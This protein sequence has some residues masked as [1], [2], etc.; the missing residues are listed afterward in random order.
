MP[1]RRRSDTAGGPIV[2]ERVWLFASGRHL[3]QT[4]PNLT[5]FDSAT[6]LTDTRED[7]GAAKVTVAL[8]S[9]Q[10]LEGQWLGARQKLTGTPAAN[11]FLAGDAG[12]LEDRRLTD[13][14]WSGAY[15]GTYGGRVQ[16]TARY[17]REWG[18][19][20]A[21]E[22]VTGASLSA[23]TPLIDQATGI[24]WWS[25]GA[26]TACDP[27]EATNDTLRATL[28]V[29]AG[30]HY[31]TIGGDLTRDE[32]RN[33]STPAGGAFAVRATRTA[34]AG[35]VTVPVFG[36]D[37]STWIVW[38][39]DGASGQD[40]RS[41]SVFLQD[42][43]TVTS[44]LQIDWGVR[45]DR[46]R[47]RATPAD[48]LLLSEQLVSPR[49]FVTWRPSADRPWTV[50]GGFARYG[51]DPTDRIAPFA[52]VSTRVF[53]Y[54][55][56]PVNVNAATVSS[57]DA[58]DILFTSFQAQG[59]TSR[60]PLFAFEPGLS[61][62]VTGSARPRASTNG[63]PASVACSASWVT[64]EPTWPFAAMATSAPARSI[65]APRRSTS[66]AVGSMCLFRS[67]HRCSSGST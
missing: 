32:V 65:E 56:P 27:H 25:S 13:N 6:F 42:R 45:F 41:E 19:D 31:F 33:A 46:S 15:V 49:V 4:V 38:Q 3:T 2:R 30:P 29:S 16:I 34:A 63:Q 53:T 22:R 43:W 52:G 48:A 55:G 66:S 62:Q 64:P 51:I 58:L 14:A 44:G 59:G 60:A 12:A 39:P 11:A 50:D 9:N 61:L 47:V 40:V 54:G 1:L 18:T 35:G 36:P 37:G 17:T 23:R 10:R 21:D 28:G 67:S 8:G 20:R 24:R 26:C 5:A 57:A 7:F